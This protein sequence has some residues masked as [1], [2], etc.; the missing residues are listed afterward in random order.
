MAAAWESLVTKLDELDDFS[1]AL[2]LLHWDQQVMMPPEGA[3]GR[4]RTVA[5][6]EAASHRLLTAPRIGELIAEL[7]S[8]EGLDDVQAASLRVL[9]RDY[10]MATKVP[11]ELVREL[12]EVQGLA[13]AAWT[14]ARPADDFAILQPHL[15]RLVELKKREADALGW[16]HERYDALLDQY[17]PGATARGLAPMFEE[18]VEGLKPLTDAA[19]ERSEPGA[20]WLYASYEEGKQQAFCAWLVEQLGFDTSSGRLD[21]SPHPFTMGVGVGDVRQTVR[22]E[23]SGVFGAVYAAMHETGHALYEQGIPRELR[24]LPVGRVPSL[25]M[26]E[27]QS[28]LWENQ[29]GRSRAFTD[30]LLPHLKERFPEEL[31]MVTPENF[32]A[33][34]NRVQ[35]SLIRVTADELTY[36]LHIAVRLELELAVFRDELEVAALPSAFNAAMDRH[37]GIQPQSDADGVLQDM[38]WAIGAFGYFPTYTLGTLYAA[39]LYDRAA[40]DLDGLEDDIR[41]GDTKRLLQWLRERIHTRGYMLESGA[42]VEEVVGEPVG[43][44]PLLAYLTDKYSEL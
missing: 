7:S 16:E 38:H 26:H 13:Y 3:R 19:L 30:Y 27:S 40:Q 32:Y 42:L 39:A 20:D 4:A 14:R 43:A 8:A 41:S 1:S 29:V 34:V 10:E 22:T 9:R 37:L 31:G 25:G 44:K 36:N 21:R 23:S 28:R 6:I 17:E 15:E 2:K 12:A 35:R 5:T 18:L 11:D 33:G 24:G